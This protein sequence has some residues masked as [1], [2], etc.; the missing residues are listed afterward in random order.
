MSKIRNETVADEDAAKV[1]EQPEFL[2]GDFEEDGSFIG[3]DGVQVADFDAGVLRHVIDDGFVDGDVV[4][5]E[6]DAFVCAAAAEGGD[7][8]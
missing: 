3:G 7:A 2:I 5:D 4:V 1:E 8:A 6:G